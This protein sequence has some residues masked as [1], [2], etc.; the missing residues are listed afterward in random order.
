MDILVLTRLAS[1]SR[2]ILALLS[3][4]CLFAVG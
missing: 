3:T 4:F 1:R 2:H